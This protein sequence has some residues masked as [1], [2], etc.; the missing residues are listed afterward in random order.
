[1]EKKKE[2]RKKK[3][4]ERKKEKE[5]EKE[6]ERKKRKKEKEKKKK[7]RK[8]GKKKAQIQDNPDNHKGIHT[9]HFLAFHSVQLIVSIAR[10]CARCRLHRQ[11]PEDG[12]QPR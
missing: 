5:K 3:E 10:V 6:K 11:A 7:K 1:M 12:E 8:G 4:K 9:I 2:E